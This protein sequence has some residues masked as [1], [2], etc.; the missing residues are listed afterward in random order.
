MKLKEDCEA[1]KATILVSVPR[2]YNRIVEGVKTAVN[3]MVKEEAQRPHIEKAVF[4]KVRQS[5][6]GSIRIMATGSAPINAAVQ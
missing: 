2:I 5:F 6:G 3:S 1:V 4:G